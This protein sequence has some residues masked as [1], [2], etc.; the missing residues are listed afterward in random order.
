MLGSKNSKITT[1]VQ[2]VNQEITG[3][4]D[5]INNGNTDDAR[6]KLE[7]ARKITGKISNLSS[8]VKKSVDKEFKEFDNHIKK[9]AA[10]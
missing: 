5:N 1:L 6:A 10:S 2:I 3:A 4:I 9:F 8:L 7:Y